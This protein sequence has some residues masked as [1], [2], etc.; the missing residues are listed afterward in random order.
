M[1]QRGKTVA[2]LMGASE[3]PNY[4]SLEPEDAG[5]RQALRQAFQNSHTDILN[6]LTTRP[7][8]R[9]EDKDVLD[10]FDST[11]QPGELITAIN[12]FLEK[13][14]AESDPP[15]DIIFYYCGHGAYL[16]EREYFL[17]LRCT[18]RQSKEATVF[19]MGYLVD[20]IREH[21]LAWRN[22]IILDACYSGAA[23]V[24]LANLSDDDA[25]QLLNSE[26]EVLN[27]GERASD[28]E[29]TGAILFC[30][31]GPK[32]WAITP[33]EAKHT[34]FSG[35]L[36]QALSKG[37]ARSGPSLSLK[38]LA[39]LVREEIRGAF[40]RQGVPPQIHVPTQ[41]NVDLLELPYFPNPKFDPTAFGIRLSQLEATVREM[42]ETVN[43]AVSALK[44]LPDRAATK[45]MV[46]NISYVQQV[47]TPVIDGIGIYETPWAW[48]VVVSV[49]FLMIMA[50]DGLTYAVL[51]SS[52][53]VGSASTGFL[54]S[55]VFAALI[56]FL[57]MM[58]SAWVIV[59]RGRSRDS[60][61]LLILSLFPRQI[62]YTTIFWNSLAMMIVLGYAL[63]L[64]DNAIA[65]LLDS[66]G[67]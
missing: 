61:A 17:A 20:I 35:A 8:L 57:V 39:E 42:R 46:E 13:H 27:Q 22:L 63:V 36:L 24:E 9:L 10:V 11:L 7:G 49:T 3:F 29:P 53:R 15:T 12:E 26:L 59:S 62:S 14:L 64:P 4:P 56:H 50:V 41:A 25:G 48:V 32:R 19:K 34:M 60:P 18:S 45:E 67:R 33:L 44:Q 31:A 21:T 2:V 65:L 5:P 58:V 23:L 52:A 54:F 43:Q 38:R 28:V 30:A 16:K 66:R 40:G 1:A 51:L 55:A 6:Y 37:D 47:E